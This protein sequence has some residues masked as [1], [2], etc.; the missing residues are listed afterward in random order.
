MAP[1]AYPSP[2]A[3][4]V[5]VR[6]TFRNSRWPVRVF[7]RDRCHVSRLGADRLRHAGAALP[8]RLVERT[9]ARASAAAARHG[10][11]IVLFAAQFA[12]GLLL[13]DPGASL[14]SLLL[15]PHLGVHARVDRDRGWC[16]TGVFAVDQPLRRVGALR[17]RV[18]A[19]RGGVRGG[20][21]RA[22]RDRRG[23]LPV[24]AA[25]LLAA[26]AALL[27][28]PVKRRLNGSPTEGVSAARWTA[29]GCSPGSVRPWN[30]PRARRTSD[31]DGR[32]GSRRARAHLVPRTPGS[33]GTHRTP[34]IW[35]M[36]AVAD[37]DLADPAGG[38][39]AN[40]GS[41]TLALADAGL[42]MPG[43]LDD[44]GL[45][46]RSLRGAVRASLVVTLVGRRGIGRIRCGPRRDDLCS[47]RIA[48]LRNLAVR[49]PPPY[50]ICISPPSGPHP[51]R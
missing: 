39:A 11:R 20:R 6:C 40:T 10:G 45:I 28:Q 48:V 4:V 22:G 36:P 25:V 8:A 37:A 18:G 1:G 42:A 49:P 2:D 26:A 24:G 44:A 31:G 50:A 41:A 15:C 21:D 35:N 34:P 3:P 38:R 51:S 27:F 14:A 29:I 5:R 30:P 19:H 7:S 43:R 17:V 13:D 32:G 9:P 12:A 33:A 16:T 46:L 47:T 23:F